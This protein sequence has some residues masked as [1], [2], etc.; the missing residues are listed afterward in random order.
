MELGIDGGVQAITGQF[1]GHNLDATLKEITRS[2]D[3]DR[4]LVWRLINLYGVDDIA[5]IQVI[6]DYI[7]DL[8]HVMDQLRARAHE[9]DV[10]ISK[11]DE[12]V[13]SSKQGGYRGI[14]ITL[15]ADVRHLL[16]TEDL[17][18]LEKALDLKASDPMELPCE[19]Q[20]CTTLQNSEALKSHDL[21]YK[22]EED[23]D[24]S[25]LEL[26]QILS[27]Q[28]HEGDKTSDII[29]DRVETILLPD[30]FG[31]RQLLNYLRP[32]LSRDGFTLVELGLWCAK[33]VHQDDLRLSGQPYISHI[34]A[35][36]ERL[37]YNFGITDPEM[38]FLAF[39][40][41]LWMNP[42]PEVK[43]RLLSAE[44][45]DYDQESLCQ[46]LNNE[47]QLEDTR[48]RDNILNYFGGRINWRARLEEFFNW[49][50]VLLG[51]FQQFWRDYHK[52]HPE[53]LGARQ[54]ERLWRLRN[55]LEREFR[56]RGGGADLND[57]LQRAFVLEAAILLGQLE[58]LPDEPNHQRAEEQFRNA[59]EEFEIITS[60]LPPSPIK[61]KIIEETTK[62]FQETAESLDV[63]VPIN[64]YR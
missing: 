3:L 46:D 64:W 44:G 10:T 42:C 19:V 18:K 51:S 38:L 1:D 49:F 58:E 57:W 53:D 45:M 24:K 12:A 31:E 35:T 20:L 59:Y 60:N 11:I 17:K 61:V 22:R 40:H 7:S 52:E 32:R 4:P 28:L 55:D 13:E 25:F 16:P 36:C 9:W 14:H 41:D 43:D 56:R 50:W 39:L 23:V 34:L 29:R 2:T 5:G 63:E 33:R 54:R 47:I 21:I 62:V 30:D 26:L 6:C 8:V 37:V 27:N 15:M 48:G